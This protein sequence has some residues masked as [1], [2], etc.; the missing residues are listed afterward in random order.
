MP[1]TR[2]FLLSVWFLI[3]LAA[4]AE[5]SEGPVVTRADSSGITIVENRGADETLDW[6]LEQLFV[7]GGADDGP[8]SFHVVRPGLVDADAQG[9]IY[10]VDGAALASVVDVRRIDQGNPV[11]GRH[12]IRVDN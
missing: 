10:V 12:L 5:Q 6:T 4:C 11:G 1:V 3:I 7:L 9:N 2:R 8:E